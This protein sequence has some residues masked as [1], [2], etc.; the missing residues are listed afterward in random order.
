M[1]VLAPVPTVTLLGSTDGTEHQVRVFDRLLAADRLPTP[2]AVAMQVVREASNPDVTST[3]ISEILRQDPA[4]CGQVFKAINSGMYAMSE[5]ITS[6]ERAVLLLGLNAVRSIVLAVSLPAMQ[7]RGMRDPAFREFWQSAVSGAMIGRELAVRLKVPSPDD[8]MLAGLLRDI[9]QLVFLQ[10]CP[11]ETRVF[12]AGMEHRPYTRLCEYERELFGVT[13][14]EL[15]GELLRRWNLPASLVEPIHHHHH[16]AG[17]KTSSPVL[18]GRCERLGFVDALSQLDL[19]SQCPND[20]DKLLKTAEAQ[21]A[22]DQSELIEFL[23]GVVPRVEEFTALLNVDIGQCPN[24]AATLA[25]GSTE[26]FK[27]TVE[28]GSIGVGATARTPPP[29]PVRGNQPPPVEPRLPSFRMEHLTAFPP[30]GCMLD[31]YELRRPLGSGAMGVVYLGHELSLDRPVAVKIL[32]P[33]L[34]TDDRQRQRFLREARSVAAI[35]SENVVSI[36]SV[37]EAGPFNYFSMEM[38]DGESLEDRIESG[39]PFRVEELIALAVDV[40]NGLAAAHARKI[41]HRDVKP[42]NILL[43]RR[44]GMAKVTDFG[45]AQVET[46]VRLTFDGSLIGTPLYMSPEQATCKPSGPRSDLYSLGAVL[47][48]AACGQPP[49]DA[50]TVF[51]VLMKVCEEQPVP[52]R[53]RRPD[54]PAWF[55]G[56]VMKLL[57]KAEVDRY[58]SAEEVLRV[59]RP[60]HTK[61]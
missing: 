42:A 46:D 13:H 43:D 22:L 56:M 41:V 30:G 4:L 14:A 3:R 52:L 23:L 49:F 54:L 24:Y 60:H 48:A 32:L 28:S 37:K 35:R 58:Q 8:D 2:P 38:I 50:P 44:T 11:E 27:L 39:P 47:Y 25:Q 34:A 53:D 9:G 59:L 36:Y 31:G 18:R 1:N 33:E 55:G 20:L 51:G 17:L 10:E 15:S 5:Q 19:V 21:Y 40:A 45:L 12:R 6:L 16:P 61:R 29:A 7:G 57:A 26:L